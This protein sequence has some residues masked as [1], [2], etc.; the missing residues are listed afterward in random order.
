VRRSS[1]RAS[2]ACFKRMLLS[3]EGTVAP[4]RTTHCALSGGSVAG[5]Q[6]PPPHFRKKN[7]RPVDEN[8]ARP[9]WSLLGRHDLSHDG[10]LDGRPPSDVVEGSSSNGESTTK[11]GPRPMRLD[12]LRGRALCTTDTTVPALKSGVERAGTG[13]SRSF[14]LVAARSLTDAPPVVRNRIGSNRIESTHP[15]DATGPAS[16]TGSDGAGAR[17]MNP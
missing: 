15:F 2:L 1:A 8:R 10:G 9:C 5:K 7:A 14:A 13:A 3:D 16:A 12:C 11:P 6:A 17:G 4:V